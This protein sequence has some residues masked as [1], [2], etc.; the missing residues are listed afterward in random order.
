[1]SD[2]PL[3]YCR[4]LETYLC[5]KNDGHLIRISGPSFDLVR[6]WAEQGIPLRVATSGIDRTFERYYAKGARRKPVHISFCE[7]DVLDAFDAWRRA[8]GVAAVDAQASEVRPSS[9][10]PAHIERLVARLTARRASA[11]ANTSLDRALDALV[12]ELDVLRP[13]AAHARGEARAAIIDRLASLDAEL[14]MLAGTC[15]SEDQQ[16]SAAREAR[17]DLEPFRERMSP[18]AYRTAVQAAA[19]RQVRAA[20]DL[21]HARYFED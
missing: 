10:L 12:R 3:A 18:D 11:G 5:R 9:S 1:V 6:G 2:D 15:T 20:A 16:A 19:D 7:Q 17:A 14:Q 8:T 21:P 4:D 13:Q